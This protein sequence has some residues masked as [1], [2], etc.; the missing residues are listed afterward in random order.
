MALGI[1]L[2]AHAFILQV[3]NWQRNVFCC[4]TNIELALFEK[5][6]KNIDSYNVQ[7]LGAIA[8]SQYTASQKKAHT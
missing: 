8:P 7:L 6:Q 4:A 1:V 3:Q 2:V 5:K